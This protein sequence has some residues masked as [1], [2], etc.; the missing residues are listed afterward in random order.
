MFESGITRMD[1]RVFLGSELHAGAGELGILGAAP[2]RLGH[3][4]QNLQM[5][6]NVA[7]KRMA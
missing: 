6:D 2:A 1:S 7:T 5:N 4:D 3:S